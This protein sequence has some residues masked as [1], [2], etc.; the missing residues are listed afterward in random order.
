MLVSVAGVRILFGNI[1]TDCFLR[2]GMYAGKTSL[3]IPG[4]MRGSSIDYPNR[5][6]RTYFFA[7]AATDTRISNAN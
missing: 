6:G 2:A 3:A 1:K 7:N 5:R 4:S